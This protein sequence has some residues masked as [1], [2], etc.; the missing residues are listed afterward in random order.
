MSDMNLRD[1]TVLGLVG[2][3]G[4]FIFAMNAY[5]WRWELF[6]WSFCYLF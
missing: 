6:Y 2:A 3:G 4:P 1:A 5:K